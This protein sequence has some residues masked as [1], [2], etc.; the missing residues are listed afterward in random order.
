[1]NAAML[2]G[3]LTK[4]PDIRFTQS[5]LAVARFTLAVNRPYKKDKE[6]E[7]DFIACVAFGK[8]AEVIGDYVY[9]GQRLIVEGRIQTGYYKDKEG[10]TKYTT[11]IAVNRAEFVEKRPE[12]STMVNTLKENK[13]AS[14]GNFERFGTEVEMEQGEIPF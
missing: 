10:K 7:A 8:T 4:D 14:T 13:N 2:M 12:D 3:R 5:G 9:K 11:E 1:M 6:Q